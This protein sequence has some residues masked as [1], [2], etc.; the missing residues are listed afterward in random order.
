MIVYRL[1]RG[2]GRLALRWFYR[3]VEVV[4]MERVPTP[5]RCCSR[6]T[7]RMHSVDALVIGCSC[8]GQ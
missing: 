6:A 1:L 2:L 5:D 3:D 4:G 7:I 8:A